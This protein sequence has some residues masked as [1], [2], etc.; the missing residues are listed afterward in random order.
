MTLVE[1]AQKVIG[2]RLQ[3]INACKKRGIAAPTDEQISEYINEYGMDINE[4][5]GDYTEQKG[6][7]RCDEDSYS[8][9]EK[10][11]LEATLKLNDD[12]L[13]NLW[14]TFI[15]E[16]CLYGKDS[17]IYD[18]SDTG[19]FRFLWKNI[20]DKD[21]KKVFKIA[22]DGFR[23]I[24][25]FNLNDG[26]ILPRKNIK[27]II[28]AYWG[29]IFERIMLYP[30]AYDIDVEVF[31]EGDGSTYFSDVFFPVI[32]KEIGYKIDGYNGTIEKIVKK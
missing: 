14:N 12:N 13:V 29:E 23:F 20:A 11:L 31:A 6:M 30:N 9:L 25:W 24:Q 8:P 27:G 4:F 2:F 17:Y 32:A 22:N 10:K 16:S 15:N 19:D 26:E 1:K 21:K 7:F 3:I 18:L 5:M 28:K